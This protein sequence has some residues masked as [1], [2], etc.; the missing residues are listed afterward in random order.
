MLMPGVFVELERKRLLSFVERVLDDFVLR[1]DHLENEPWDPATRMNTE[2]THKYLSLC[3]R[4]R[5]LIDHIKAVKRQL[6]KFSEELDVV[7]E[8]MRL[9]E[10][11]VN[12]EKEQVI[13]E[14]GREMKKRIRD[15]MDEFNDKM[16]DC[17]MVICNTSLAM[18]TV[19]N[20]I[21]RQDSKT[22]TDISK[23]NAAIAWET[24]HESAQMR[25]IALL[26][27]IYLPLS[28]VA[29]IFSMDM[30]NWEANAGESVVSKHIWLFAALS[31]G[32]TMITLVAW[33]LGTRRAK[34]MTRKSKKWYDA[35]E[36]QNSLEV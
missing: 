24:K 9:R 27:M 25:T 17:N 29:A 4:S 13:A 16:D 20:H 18:Q 14:V 7:A 1:A 31:A 28:S 8:E 34:R 30:F 6:A 19:W 3:L 5:S 23:A 35:P 2:E 11:N 22:N 36:R 10:D 21:A 15:V 26:T 12:R 32:L 33:F